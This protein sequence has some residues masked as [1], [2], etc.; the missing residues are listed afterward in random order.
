[1]KV[2]NPVD[3][4]DDR[5]EAR[6]PVFSG[7]DRVFVAPLLLDVQIKV[8]F[9]LFLDGGVGGVDVCLPRCV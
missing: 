8:I 6:L 9:C 3:R 4:L 5:F 7:G 2:P 1:M